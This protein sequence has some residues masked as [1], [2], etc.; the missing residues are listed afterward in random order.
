MTVK[1]YGSL[2]EEAAQI[3]T[4][5]FCKEQRFKDEFDATDCISTH[6][7]AFDGKTAIATCRVF[8]DAIGNYHI[9]RIAVTKPFRGNKVGAKL[10]AAAQEFINEKGG[11]QIVISA[12]VR[13]SKFYKKLGFLPVGEIYYGEGCPHIKMI[14]KL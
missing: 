3:R 5:V 13:V 2:P 14:K 6:F 4:A 11:K 1:I 12:Q 7:V 10:L 9:G 8:N